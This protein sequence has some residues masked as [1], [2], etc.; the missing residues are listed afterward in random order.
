MWTAEFAAKG[1]LQ[2]LKDK[3]ALDTSAAAARRPCRR[4]TYQGTLYAAPHT[5]DGGLLYYRKD[6]VP[7]PPK[8]WAELMADCKIAKQ[9]NIGCYAGQF[10]KYEG[11]TVN[12]AE[13]INAAGGHSSTRTAR[14][15]TSNTPQAAKGLSFL[16]D[17]YKNGD[18][19]KEA[20]TYQEE[21]GRAGLRV[22]QAAVPAQL[23]VRL[24]PG[25]DRRQLGGQGQVRR[26]PA[27]RHERHRRVA[28]WAVTTPRISAYS[29]HKATALDFMKFLT[30]EDAQQRRLREGFAG[31]GA[32]VAVRRP[33]AGRRSSRYLQTLKIARQRRTAVR[34]RR[35]TPASPKAIEDNAYAAIKGDKSV[36]QALKDMQAAHHRPPAPD[37]R[38]LGS[39]QQV[40]PLPHPLQAPTSTR[41]AACRE[42]AIGTSVR[43]P[44][45][46]QPESARDRSAK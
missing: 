6:L 45:T 39:G 27:A 7:T 11:L 10:A 29:K 36:S 13:A 33:G 9:H 19:P 43:R 15:R 1:W 44:G 14:P 22:R 41:V 37:D 32:Q 16:A 46:D 5:T 34:S 40:R 17:A 25:R 3:F 31:A 12:A 26:R 28:P 4:G 8:T 38:P 24:Q 42:E 30:S 2:P 18:I 21:Q 23:A 35:S 20:I